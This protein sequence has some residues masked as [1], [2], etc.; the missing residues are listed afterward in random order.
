MGDPPPER[1]RDGTGARHDLV[2]G[3]VG[4]VLGAIV[5]AFAGQLANAV[6]DPTRPELAVADFAVATQSLALKTEDPELL[7]SVGSKEGSM[8]A[9]RPAITI[10]IH[11]KGDQRAVLSQIRV[12]VEDHLLIRGCVEG[13]GGNIPTSERYG[14]VLPLEPPPGLIVTRLV[15]QEIGP[16]SVDKFSL[17][18][19]LADEPLEEIR[20]YR[21][22]LVIV[23]DDG[24]TFNAGN[25]VVALPQDPPAA[26]F[27]AFGAVSLDQLKTPKKG[28]EPCYRANARAAGRFLKAAGTRTPALQA[29]TAALESYA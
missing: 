14:L 2:V 11:N 1:N 17:V 12:T 22:K 8:V 18:L 21:L 13:V 28:E 15:S 23:H 29:M 24:Q 16:D 3:L 7:E 19:G 27:T 20:L 9:S 5:A 4:V 26:F 25:A 6:L 10:T